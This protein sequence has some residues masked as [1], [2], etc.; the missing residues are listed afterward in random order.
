MNL[1]IITKNKRYADLFILSRFFYRFGYDILKNDD[2]YND[3]ELYIKS[4]GV[5]K[6]Y[7]NRTYDDDPIPF[8]LLKEIDA[9]DY[10]PK[11]KE[12]SKYAEGLDSEKT[13]SIRPVTDIKEVW[14]FW[15]TVKGSD[16][17]FSLK[18]DGNNSKT[19]YPFREAS[20]VNTLE[21]CL[22]R[23]RNEGVSIDYTN[24]AVRTLPLTLTKT[25]NTDITVYSEF[26][27]V[28][29]YLPVLRNKYDKEKY[30]TAKSS[31]MSMLRV[32]HDS[33]DYK[34]LYGI[35]FDV[36][37]IP[38]INTLEDKFNT[39]KELGFK[40][41][42]HKLIKASNIPS[43]YEE[44]EIFIKH[45][46]KVF[47]DA[48]KALPSDGLVMEVNDLNFKSNINHQYSSKNIAL[49]LEHWAYK[50]YIGIV[51][52]IK[53]EQQRVVA[54]CRVKIKPLR[55]EDGCEAKWINCYNP[56]ILIDEG[57]KIGS[58]IVFERKSGA[59]NSLVRTLEVF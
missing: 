17:M 54:S 22:S 14:N 42:P 31:A 13:V 58:P 8:E 23:A 2:I 33:E 19:L 11:V 29:A 50:E 52:D 4:K 59:I 57:V 43:T 6:D 40:V 24:G 30:K 35:A 41:V 28:P 47:A 1:D 45:I 37:G 9:L 26:F 18:M 12:I 15:Q 27:V 32:K 46:C 5:L 44:F 53:I 25:F 20:N 36:D 34:Y 39:L 51:E 38:N 16:I 3:L 56:S 48:T 21:V 49:K 10:L 7:L 55:T